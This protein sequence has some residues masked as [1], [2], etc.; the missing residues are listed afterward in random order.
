MSTQPATRALTRRPSLRLSEGEVTHLARTPINVARAF[1]QHAA[2]LT[3]LSRH[4]LT[5]ISLPELPDHP[6]GLFVED[7]L[8]MLDGLALLTRPG[9]AS[10]RGEVASAEAALAALGR[11]V[12]R[13]AAPATLDGGDVLLLDRHVL[14]GRSTRSNDAGREQLAR[15]AQ[16]SMRTV[17]GVDVRGALHL[18]TAVTRL[19]DG[20]LIAVPGF[21]D[22]AQLEALGYRVHHAREASGGDV[23][24]L[25]ETVVLPSD[26]PRTAAMLQQEGFTVESLDIS[27][28]QRLEA[29]LTCMSVLF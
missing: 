16:G 10:R 24:C 6:D 11:P 9:A 7:I 3:L 23:L 4:G 12:A 8:V 1:A 19:P 15:L 28:L 5:L 26:A 17:L 20:A 25:G 2:Y 22:I 13:I 27:E 21:V 29:G 14:V 18:K